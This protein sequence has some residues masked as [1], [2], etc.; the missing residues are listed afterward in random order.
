MTGTSCSACLD[1]SVD[2]LITCSHDTCIDFAF[3]LTE[4]HSEVEIKLL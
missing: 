1:A 2:E 3:K 4:C